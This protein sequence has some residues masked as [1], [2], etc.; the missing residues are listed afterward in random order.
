MNAIRA[1]LVLFL[2]LSTTCAFAADPPDEPKPPRGKWKIGKE[3]TFITEPL[4]KDGYPDY[5]TALNKRL[6]EGVTPETNANVMIWRAL[7]PHPDKANLPPEYFKWLGVQPPP[8]NGDYFIKLSDYLKGEPGKRIE[9]FY[10]HLDRAQ[11]RPWTEKDYPELAAWLK[12]NEKPLAIL[13]E[14]S[15]RPQYFNPLVPSNPSVPAKGLIA[16]TMPSAHECRQ[17]TNA[18]TARAMLLTEKKAYAEAWQTLLA[19]HRLARMVGRGG[20]LIERLVSMGMENLTSIADLAFLDWSGPNAKQIEAF[21][22]DL[23]ALPPPAPLAD[24]VD[25][26]ERLEFLEVLLMIDRQGPKVLEEFNGVLDEKILEGIDWD[27]AMRFGNDWFD[28][29]TAAL[30]EEDCLTRRSKLKDIYEARG[31]RKSDPAWDLEALTKEPP[32]VRGQRVGQLVLREF[33]PQSHKFQEFAD[34]SQQIFNNT[35]TAFGLAWYQR[36]HGLYPRQL[37]EL[38]PKYLPRAPLD[39]F[40]GKALVYQPSTNGYLFY[41]FGINGADDGGRNSEDDPPGDDLRVR[42]PL[43]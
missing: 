36:E 28:R 25:L 22:K 19:C 29:L 37:T 13:L 12:A 39:I 31:S 10:R 1:C 40:T 7:G 11:K 34:R 2:F 18:L 17:M 30:R 9:L 24:K 3:T 6:S 8:E 27:A 5:I 20:T 26:L 41:S 14:A 16:A 43:P 38:A 15:K 4:D 21:L 32:N 33:F 35:V 42:M 23:Q